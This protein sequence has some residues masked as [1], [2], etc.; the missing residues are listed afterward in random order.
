M[1]ELGNERVP[2]LFIIDFLSKT[3]IVLSLNQI[4]RHEILYSLNGETNVDLAEFKLPATNLMFD[5]TPISYDYYERCYQKIQSEIAYGNTYLLNLT[6]PTEIGMNWSLRDVFD[7]SK[8]KYKLLYKDQFTV[9]SPE[10][11]IKISDGRIY[12]YPMK[13][14]I[15]G[16]IPDAESIILADE[17]ETAE[18]FTIVDLIRND[19]NMVATEVKVDKF[20]YIDKL[21]TDQGSILQ[22]S[23]QISGKME[24]DW[25][26]KIGEIIF[27]LLPAGSISGAPKERTVEIIQNTEE[28]ERG[29]YTGIMGIFTG[30]TLD[31]G[32]MIRF[33]EKTDEGFVFKSGGGITSKSDVIKE[34][35]ELIQKIYVPII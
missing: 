5:L 27:K 23:S 25:Q 7:N 31:S 9:F 13:G 18:H 22:V 34:Y 24:A 6:F 21:L 20:R 3:P 35:N 29:Y 15:D 12:S 8:A 1:N 4:I 26:S 17:K 2:F 28:Y 19:L 16:E 33:I 10:T 11:F 14:T 30:D 32:V